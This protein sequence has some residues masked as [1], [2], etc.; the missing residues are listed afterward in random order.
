M[1]DGSAIPTSAGTI[2]IKWLERIPLTLV[3]N[4]ARI[5]RSP[6]IVPASPYLKAHKVARAHH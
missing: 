6:L 2:P 1:S 5:R 3:A 4:P